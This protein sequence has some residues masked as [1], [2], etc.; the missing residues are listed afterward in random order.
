MPMASVE[1]VVAYNEAFA[2]LTEQS[3]T[4]AEAAYKKF[5]AAAPAGVE[6]ELVMNA[7]STCPS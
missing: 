2:Q 4:A 5:A 6:S 1:D 7:T 3:R